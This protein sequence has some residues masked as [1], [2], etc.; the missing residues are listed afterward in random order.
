M[1]VTFTATMLL[2]ALLLFL[3]Q[4][5]FARMVLPLLGS[6][7]A[8]WNTA[9]VFYQAVL[10]AGY[11]Y[12]HLTN[13]RL[14]HRRQVTLHGVLVLLALLV[15]PLAVPGD[16]TPPVES[17][18]IPWLLA[19][20]IVSAGLPFFVISATSPLLQ[21]WF[22]R[23]NHPAASDPYF[24]YAASNLGSMVA[25]LS[26][27][28]LL[29]PNLR[30]LDQSRAWSVVYAAFA[31][32]ILV[33]GA[34]A[35]RS[36]PKLDA[37]HTPSDHPVPPLP[38]PLARQLRWL[39]LAFVPAGLLLSVTAYLST[40]IPPVP[41]LWVVPL[42]LYLLSFIVAFARWGGIARRAVAVVLPVLLLLVA[43]TLMSGITRPLPL[44]IGLHLALLFAA[45]LLCHGALAADR[46]HTAH[47]ARF[48]VWLSA[49]GVLGGAFTALLAPVL[50]SSL[51]EYPLMLGLLGLLYAHLS[52]PPGRVPNRLRDIGVP[53][54][55]GVLIALVIVQVEASGVLLSVP[56]AALLIG[57]PATVYFL[58]FHRP[59][60]FATG[61]GAVLVVGLLSIGAEGGVLHTERSFFGIH[62]VVRDADG[63]HR[64][65]HG[66]TLHGMQS[67]DPERRHEPLTYYHRSGPI[68]QLFAAFDRTDSRE[69][70]GVVGLGAGSLACYS[71]PEQEWTFYE[72]DPAVERI[73]R[74]PRYF[75]SLEEC[76][77][78]AKVVLGD[79]RLSLARKEDG[80]HDLLILDAY[81]SDAIPIHLI[82][83]EALALY[84]D[85]L[86]AGGVLAFHISNRYLDLA[87]V[88]GTLAEDAGLV[89]LVQDDGF[90]S[91]SELRLGKLA[92]R[93]VILAR[94]LDHLADLPADPRWR[95]VPPGPPSTLWTDDFSSI[96][97]V[98]R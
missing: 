98:L 94:A 39:L 89:A 79:A 76:A 21:T 78:H 93:W 28:L 2:G 47:L 24:L 82:T 84:L 48:Y 9:V 49:G 52:L 14:S 83:R 11:L 70:V 18:P 38:L 57:V 61:M 26:Y 86:D 50:F 41:L 88:L 33:C 97:A 56:A 44:L 4:P 90:V 37:R 1:L 71:R 7:P 12:V 23:T 19:L 63:N 55:A 30:L 40:D 66:S 45:A 59:L 81:S 64:L 15:L 6:S 53:L 96:F 36:P 95:P 51:V 69:R 54:I 92:S 60:R 43:V 31:V 65:I 77:P 3:V 8:V 85:K 32:L 10:L 73:A 35:W 27:P 72:I 74:N 25:L 67:M 34:L 42:A 80:R 20:L 22:S 58:F 75:T 87:P 5:M 29:E 46:P 62:R 68:G 91:E 16:W 13:S 17:N